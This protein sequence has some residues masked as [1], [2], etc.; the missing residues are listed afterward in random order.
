MIEASKTMTKISWTNMAYCKKIR[1]SGLCVC[2]NRA[3]CSQMVSPA[4]HS[5]KIALILMLW[6]RWIKKNQSAERFQPNYLFLPWC[7]CLTITM[8]DLRV[9]WLA[10]NVLILHP[11]ARSLSSTT[12][13]IPDQ[14]VFQLHF[15]LC[16]LALSKNGPQ[17]KNFFKKGLISIWGLKQNIN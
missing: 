12:A 4:A 5:W 6:I 13:W 17:T 1:N 7:R 8:K 16:S 14:S 2:Q 3:A 11:H 10:C 9:L 15:Y